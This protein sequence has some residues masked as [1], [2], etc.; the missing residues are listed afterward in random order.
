MTLQDPFGLNAAPSLSISYVQPDRRKLVVVERVED[1]PEPGYI[2]HG[3]TRCFDC[4]RWCHLGS[5]TMQVV[6]SGEAT[7]YCRQCAAP[8]IRPDHLIKNVVDDEQ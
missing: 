7:P 3:R 8:R 6:S 4:G 1:E 2:V 5:A